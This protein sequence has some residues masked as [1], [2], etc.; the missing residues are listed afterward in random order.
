[1]S[2]E[3]QEILLSNTRIEYGN[4]GFSIQVKQFK[5]SENPAPGGPGWLALGISD[6]SYGDMSHSGQYSVS[7]ADLVK[8]A[9]MFNKA[10]IRAEEEGFNDPI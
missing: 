8:L 2:A 6:S 7:Y 1:M 10:V 9:A 4:I 3:P 5:E